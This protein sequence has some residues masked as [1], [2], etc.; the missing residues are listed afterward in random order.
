MGVNLPTPRTLS[1]FIDLHRDPNS[2]IS[3]GVHWKRYTPD[4]PSYLR[5]NLKLE[6]V[7]GKL[8]EERMIFWE[9]LIEYLKSKCELK[10][11]ISN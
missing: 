4:Q 6:S 8:N 9:D 7:S 2:D 11:K 3:N 5:I 1:T 10:F